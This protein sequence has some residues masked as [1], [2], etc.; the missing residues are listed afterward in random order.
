[1][2]RGVTIFNHDTMLKVYPGADGMKTGYTDASGHNL[3]T[4]AV[5]DGV[6]LIGVVLGAGTNAARDVH[7]AALLNQGF[8]EMDVPT[9]A[10]RPWWRAACR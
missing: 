5:R 7:M 8:D 6:R 2:F 1:M 9:G 10:P 4:S 3:I